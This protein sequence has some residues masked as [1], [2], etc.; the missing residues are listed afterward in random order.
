M[1]GSRSD[2][3]IYWKAT[4][5]CNIKPGLVDVGH[6][7]LYCTIVQETEGCTTKSLDINILVSPLPPLSPKQTTKPT[8]CVFAKANVL[9]LQHKQMPLPTEQMEYVDCS[10]Q[11]GLT[12]QHIGF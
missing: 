11:P 12:Q 5:K 9:L 6:L 1:F 8:H 2:K 4:H 10:E 7:H 3:K